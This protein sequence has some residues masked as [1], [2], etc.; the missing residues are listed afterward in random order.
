[1]RSNTSL[2]VQTYAHWSRIHCFAAAGNLAAARAAAEAAIARLGRSPWFL[3]GLALTVRD[4][5]DRSL[6][7]AIHAELA[8]RSQ[9]EYVQ[10]HVIGATAMAAG[11]L[12]EAIRHFAE[13]ADRR[14]PLFLACARHWPLID[15]IRARPEWPDILRQI[16][17]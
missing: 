13:A 4:A 8:G 12:D 15:P 9:L 14:D 17:L 1:M 3:M 6:A 11:L 10:P 2:P 7:L 16:G 5:A